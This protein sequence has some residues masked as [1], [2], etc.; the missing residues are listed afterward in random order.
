VGISNTGQVV[1]S[2]G[3]ACFVVQPGSGKGRGN[4]FVRHTL[5][6]HWK[7]RVVQ[8]NGKC[9]AESRPRKAVKACR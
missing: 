5:S 3:N 1:T 9:V 6:H 8:H 4:V 7:K 2:T